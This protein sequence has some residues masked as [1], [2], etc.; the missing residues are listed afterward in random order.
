MSRKYSS[1]FF[2]SKMVSLNNIKAIGKKDLR[3]FTYAAKRNPS[4]RSGEVKWM[5]S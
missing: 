1:Q 2:L 5:L 4:S 3:L